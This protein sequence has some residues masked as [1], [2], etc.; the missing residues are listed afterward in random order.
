MIDFGQLAAQDS[1][2]KPFI[3]LIE[4]IMDMP[5]DSLNDMTVQSLQGMIK[6]SVTPE[7]QKQGVNNLIENFE[8]RNYTRTMVNNIVQQSQK[9]L[10][11][12]V[13]SL[14]PSTAKR[15]LLNTLLNIVFGFF[16]EAQEKYHSYDIE[17]PVLLD[18]NAKIPTYAHDTDAAADLY[19]RETITIPAHSMANKVDT[20]IHIALPEGWLAHIAPRSSIGAK[21]PLRLSNMLAVIDQDYRGPLIIM[22]D[23]I[24]DFDYTINEGDRIAQLW[25]TPSYRFK[26]VSVDNLPET[27]RGEGGIGSTGV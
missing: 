5:D 17:L 20:G 2:V 7:I 10:N 4:Q 23:N 22:F 18:N 14:Q 24:S 6:G 26:A 1:S 27:E 11:E 25:V 21:T 16:T 13:E 9:E 3:D 8:A 12:F 19:A 15:V